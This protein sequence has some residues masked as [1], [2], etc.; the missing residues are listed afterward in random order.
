MHVW[1]LRLARTLIGDEDAIDLPLIRN[2]RDTIDAIAAAAGR[3]V[4]IQGAG[5]GRY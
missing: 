2:W 3:P 5:Y 1:G 4:G